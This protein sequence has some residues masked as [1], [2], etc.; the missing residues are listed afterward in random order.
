MEISSTMSLT[1]TPV[2]QVLPAGGL[3]A[4]EYVLTIQTATVL[5][6]ARSPSLSGFSFHQGCSL[7]LTW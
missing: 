1:M 4:Y 6:T 2:Q 3:A 7:L 5:A